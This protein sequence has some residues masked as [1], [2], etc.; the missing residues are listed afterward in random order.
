M[1]LDLFQSSHKGKILFVNAKKLVVN[2]QGYAYLN[3]SH[4]NEIYQA[5]KK[6]SFIK[7]FANVVTTED[8]L[9]LEGDMNINH[10]VKQ[11]YNKVHV[12]II[13]IAQG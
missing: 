11:S 8:I 4:I 13:C 9:S 6:F 3:Q 2:N 5:Y 7:N 1:K 12:F 10:Y